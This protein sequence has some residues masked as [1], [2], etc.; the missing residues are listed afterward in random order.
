MIK[1][2]ICIL[3]V[4]TI[5]LADTTM[6][7]KKNWIDPSTIEN[8]TLDGG[9]CLGVKSLTQMKSAGWVVDD[10]KISSSKNDEG[11][12]YIYIFKKKSSTTSVSVP[13]NMKN[14]KD[15]LLLIEKEKSAK[16]K[17]D[18]AT[19][20]LAEGKKIYTST[21]SRCHGVKAEEEAYNSARALN[22]LT[23]EDM[24]VSIRDYTLHE[25]DNGMAI[26]MKPYA[27]TLNY[28]T[29]PQI[30]KYIQTLK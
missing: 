27:E 25:K 5:M 12:N 4:A 8:T 9:K 11:M 14:L 10:M 13:V 1:K 6:C 22:S 15:N 28:I 3:S 17:S 21:C 29:I 16:N 23:L 2:S 20:D 18:K 26:L 19:K 24:K 7:F 30:Y